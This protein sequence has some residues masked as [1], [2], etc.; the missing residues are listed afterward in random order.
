M[1]RASLSRKPESI[2][3]MDQSTK[4]RHT[5]AELFLENYL[6]KN[7]I[8]IGFDGNYL[9]PEQIRKAESPDQIS[10]YLGIEH[11][12]DQSLLDDMKLHGTVQGEDHSKSDLELALR[13]KK[14]C[15]RICRKQE[16]GELLCQQ[17]TQA[18]QDDA[19]Q[20]WN[21]LC[22]AIFAC[23]P[24][25]AAA[26]LRHTV[27]QVKRKMLGHEV[28][29]HLMPI[30]TSQLQGS[31]KT[32]FTKRLVSPL[33]ELVAGPV[34]LSDL[35]DARSADIFRFPVVLVDDM[36]AIDN[37][38]VPVLKSM[39]TARHLRRRRLGSSDS[40]AFEQLTTPIGTA[41]HGVERLIADPTGHRRFAVLP[42]RN[43]EVSSGGDPH[44]WEVVNDTDYVLL[45]RSVDVFGPAPIIPHLETLF[46]HQAVG[47]SPDPLRE[48]LHGL[49]VTSDAIKRITTQRSVQA[50]KL[51]TA[52]V[53]A[54]NSTM[55]QTAFGDAMKRHTTD[56]E[57]SFWPKVKHTAGYFYKLRSREAPQT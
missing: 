18:E 22:G 9:R 10:T 11:L 52:F 56:P 23:D 41:N 27:W 7:G 50:H 46:Q 55:S 40:V 44:V 39:L 57:V 14:R 12:S 24:I 25:L 17:P 34:L 30:I 2:V 38:K 3:H 15:A 51:F 53:A 45:W 49:D 47:Q 43:G 4:E 48:W 5:Q 54:T 32:Q 35:A 16:V 19:E 26:V 8:G 36:E 33:E 13:K 31:G 6:R 20:A 21:R 1:R 29:H 28:E 42:F 37:V